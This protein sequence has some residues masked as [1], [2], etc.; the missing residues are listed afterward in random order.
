[1]TS[2]NAL[3]G[4]CMGTLLDLESAFKYVLILL[5][6]KFFCFWLKCGN[7]LTSA[8]WIIAFLSL[9]I[10]NLRLPPF[11][12]KTYNCLQYVP[13]GLYR[14]LKPWQ[15]TDATMWRDSW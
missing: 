11:A 3:M 12:N 8:Y 10:T 5:L 14:H 6:N 2:G 7:F 13:S 9:F 1:M 15:S 4:C